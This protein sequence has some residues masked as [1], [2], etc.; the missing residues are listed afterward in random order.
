MK[1]P[2]TIIQI[3]ISVLLIGVILLQAKGTGLGNVFGGGGGEMYRSKR[4]MEKILYTGTFILM[5]LFLLFQQLL[6][7]TYP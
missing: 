4:G 1:T 5:I 2:L 3:V 7:P 6:R